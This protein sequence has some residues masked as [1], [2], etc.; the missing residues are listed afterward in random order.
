HAAGRGSDLAVE[1]LRTRDLR[2]CAVLLAQGV[3]GLGLDLVGEDRTLALGRVV[4]VAAERQVVIVT[5]HRQGDVDI[6]GGRVVAD[7]HLA[8]RGLA[9]L[10]R[11]RVGAGDLRITRALAPA[12][13]FGFALD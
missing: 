1:I 7:A 13:L 5:V 2:T 8:R 3:L 9:V 10:R 6:V 11:E 4:V 12:A